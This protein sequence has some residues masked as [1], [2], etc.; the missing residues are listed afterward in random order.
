[1]ATLTPDPLLFLP[2]CHCFLPL[3][4]LP[5]LMPFLFCFVTRWLWKTPLEPGELTLW[6]TT[7]ADDCPSPRIHQLL[8]VP[9][10]GLMSPSLIENWLSA[11]P[12]LCRLS[13][14]NHSTR[15][16]MAAMVV[17]KREYSAILSLS[18]CSYTLFSSPSAMLHDA[19]CNLTF[20]TPFP[21][22]LGGSS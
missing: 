7:E 1:M 17:V 8:R 6:H 11:G 19:F 14:G 5:T 10:E 22:F 9:S 13:T 18:S 16:I 21:G 4:P 12:V 2:S 20:F 15:E 3:G